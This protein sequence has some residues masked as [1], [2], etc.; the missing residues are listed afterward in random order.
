MLPHPDIGDAAL[1]SQLFTCLE[2]LEDPVRP[3][4]PVAKA[5]LDI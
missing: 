1:D 3:R 5:K 2:E 4:T